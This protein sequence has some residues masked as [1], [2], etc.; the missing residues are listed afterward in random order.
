M[1][2]WSRACVAC[3]QRRVQIACIACERGGRLPFF[4]FAFTRNDN[5]LKYGVNYRV[6]PIDLFDSEVVFDC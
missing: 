5:I 6:M 2:T 3:M 4:C 1:K